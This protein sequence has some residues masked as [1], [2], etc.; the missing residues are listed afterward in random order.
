MDETPPRG[1]SPEEAATAIARRK[2]EA[3]TE[4]DAWVLAAD[5]LLDLDGVILG[6]PRDDADARAM[7]R[8][9][10]GRAHDVITGIAVRSPTGMLAIGRARTCVTFRALSD[11][12]ITAYVATGEPRDKAGS[13]AIQA[14]AAGFV[15][16]LDG[17]VDNVIGLPVALARELLRTSGYLG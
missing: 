15:S 5:T 2:A 3:S 10:S 1:A 7:L 12:E 16:R 4:R 9:L 14:G 13:Y 6:K 8:S 11:E 17:A